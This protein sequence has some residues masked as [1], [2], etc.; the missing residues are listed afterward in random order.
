MRRRRDKGGVRKH[1]AVVAV[2][3]G[4]GALILLVARLLSSGGESLPAHQLPMAP[5][6][7]FRIPRP[8]PLQKSA[9][10]TWWAPVLSQTVARRAPD[11]RSAEV[12]TLG[13][14]TPEGTSNPVVIVGRSEPKPHEQ[15]LHVRLATL[16]ADQ[17]GWVRRNTLGAF[18][19]VRTHLIVNRRRLTAT[20][21]DEGHKIFHARVGVGR[22]ATPTPSGEF[23]VRDKLTRF[24]SSI[25]GP[26]AFG[27]SA[28][29]ATLTEWP[30]GG[31][32]GLHGTNE[33]QLIPG[34]V[35]HGCIRFTNA[36]ITHLARLM[37]IGTPLTIR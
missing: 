11:A 26:V 6:A 31:F 33:P 25:Y 34:A 32:V 10:L 35:S 14:L 2:T 3:L 30:D 27:T 21:Y 22:A 15:W 9:N 16:P 28:R 7:A 29:S 1:P 12:A 5:A 17:I 4:S 20:L 24:H 18:E 13:R 23:Y 8:E 19:M 37:P 36:D